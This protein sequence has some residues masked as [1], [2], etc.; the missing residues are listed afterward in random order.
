MGWL[1]GRFSIFAYWIA[2]SAVYWFVR[3]FAR[4]EVVAAANVPAEGR[5][6]IVA[7]HL[8]NFD[9]VLVAAC[10]PRRVRTMAKREMFETP[11]V[12]WTVWAYG[13]FPVR[14]H[15]ADMG[16]LRV[17]RNHLVAGRAVLVFPEGTRAPERALI[18]AL[19]GSAMLALLGDAPV[20]PVAVTGTEQLSGPRALLGG[21][22]RGRPTVRVRF[23]EPFSLGEGATTASR[24]EE[25]TDLLMRH[26]AA[27]LPEGYRGAY[28]PGSEGEI[29]VA[30]GAEEAEGA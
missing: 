12:G 1:R 14:R 9:P 23:G 28:G 29:V 8:S 18:P 16:A 6:L 5:A 20:V 7:N 2:T 3:V 19:P 10:S 15:S 21:L 17:G 4:L 25:A 13:A 22:L 24:A 26:I 30:R 27:L 11:L